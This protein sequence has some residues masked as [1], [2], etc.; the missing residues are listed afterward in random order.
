V[1]A[2]LDVTDGGV[3]LTIED[4]GKGFSDDAADK[5]RSRG[6]LAGIRERIVALGGDFEMG[7]NENGGARVRV[8][9][10]TDTGAGQGE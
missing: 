3:E 1:R 4:D 2:R 9:V 7:N 6:G 5:L 10:P 8:L